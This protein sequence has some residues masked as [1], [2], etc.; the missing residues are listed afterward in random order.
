MKN[1]VQPGDVVMVTASASA[2]TSGDLIVAATL[3]VLAPIT[4]MKAAGTLAATLR[5]WLD[6]VAVGAVDASAMSWGTA[7]PRSRRPTSPGHCAPRGR[8]APT[9][10]G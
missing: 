8:R 5:V 1:F 7:R 2:V 9:W 6:G 4:T 10:S 3:L